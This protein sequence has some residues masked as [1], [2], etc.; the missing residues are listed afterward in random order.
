MAY[1]YDTYQNPDEVKR[2]QELGQQVP[3]GVDIVGPGGNGRP[4]DE[5]TPQERQIY[6]PQGQPAPQHQGALAELAFSGSE[7][8]QQRLG[9]QNAPEAA[10][11]PL[12]ASQQ[13]Q[14]SKG[15]PAAMMQTTDPVGYGKVAR[16]RGETVGVAG[17]ANL[18]SDIV[19]M[20]AG[21]YAG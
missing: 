10:A 12:R 6:F 3:A 4:P 19:K 21:G 15:E 2:L 13:A 18:V 7:S 11:A 1:P 8:Q 5:V 20:I 16:V 9:A 17:V 14:A